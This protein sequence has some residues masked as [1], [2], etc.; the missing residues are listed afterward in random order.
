[1]SVAAF[2]PEQRDGVIRVVAE[3][4]EIRAVSLAGEFD[5][6]NAQALGDE[7][8][9]ALEGGNHL[10]VDLSEATFIDSSIINAL[11]RAA[12]AASARERAMVLQLGTAALVERVLGIAEIERV[13]PRTHDRQEALRIIG[14]QV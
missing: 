7:L 6:S 4:P 9:R 12:S 1:M 14:S 8:D 5:L 13:L 10:I 11:V 3:S 2:G